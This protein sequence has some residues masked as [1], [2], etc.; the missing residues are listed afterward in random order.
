MITVDYVNM[1]TGE[2]LATEFPNIT[3]ANI[4]DEILS[5]V[6]CD[7]YII[8][9]SKAFRY[10]Q[11]ICTNADIARISGLSDRVRGCH[12]IVHD[13]NGVAYSPPLLRLSLDCDAP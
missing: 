13:T 4:K 11:S 6:S 10:I 8:L 12:N 2:P 9:D 7:E 1:P 3:P 5:I